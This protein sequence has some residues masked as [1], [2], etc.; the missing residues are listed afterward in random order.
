MALAEKKR[1]IKKEV[2]GKNVKG[3]KKNGKLIAL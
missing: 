1:N 2:C 3:G